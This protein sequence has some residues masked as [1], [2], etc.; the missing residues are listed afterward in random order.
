MADVIKVKASEV[1]DKIEVLKKDSKVLDKLICFFSQNVKEERDLG[2]KIGYNYEPISEFLTRVE[3]NIYAE[4]K[5]LT[6]ILNNT[7]VQI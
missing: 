4:R 3:N 2:N 6:D 7:E 1:V 5:R